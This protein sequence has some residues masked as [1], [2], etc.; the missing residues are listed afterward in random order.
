M[1]LSPMFFFHLM[2]QM[3]IGQTIASRDAWSIGFSRSNSKL[4]VLAWYFQVNWVEVDW[5]S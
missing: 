1:V 3:Q 5:A 4:V 2:P